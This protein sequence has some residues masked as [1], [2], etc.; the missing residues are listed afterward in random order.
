MDGHEISLSHSG[1]LLSIVSEDLGQPEVSRIPQD[2]NIEKSN[3]K[4]R[5]EC[6]ATLSK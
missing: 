6:L 1:I 4:K 5:V 2:P 3:H